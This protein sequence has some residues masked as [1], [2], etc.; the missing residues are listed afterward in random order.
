MD[1]SYGW[2]KPVLSKKNSM[3]SRKTP[4]F[5]LT[6]TEKREIHMKYSITWSDPNLLEYFILGGDFMHIL[7]YILSSVFSIPNLHD[8]WQH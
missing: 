3:L 2:G 1:T 8:F 6:H 7:Y 5:M 4:G